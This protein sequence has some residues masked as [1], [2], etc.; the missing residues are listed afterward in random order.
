MTFHN[1]LRALIGGAL[2]TLAVTPPAGAEG[3]FDIPAGA[4]LNPQKLEKAQR[5]LP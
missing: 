3:T 2:L 4:H 5:I 1:W